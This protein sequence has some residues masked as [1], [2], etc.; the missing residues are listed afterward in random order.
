MKQSDQFAPV[1][2]TVEP[3]QIILVMLPAIR[4]PFVRTCGFLVL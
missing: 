3:F 2:Q 1:K 4:F